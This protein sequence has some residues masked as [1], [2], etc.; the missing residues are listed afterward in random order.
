MT[1][2]G[3]MQFSKSLSLKC[4]DVGM[5]NHPERGEKNTHTQKKTIFLRAKMHVLTI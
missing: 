4:S 2:G 3:G 1:H 5:K